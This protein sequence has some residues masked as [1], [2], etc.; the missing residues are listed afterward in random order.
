M[1]LHRLLQINMT[2]KGNALFDWLKLITGWQKAAFTAFV[3]MVIG[4]ASTFGYNNFSLP[5]SEKRM[6]HLEESVD[7][8]VEKSIQCDIQDALIKNN[9]SNLNIKVDEF[10][11]EI[12]NILKDLV[13]E[14]RE[15]SRITRIIKENTK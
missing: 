6:D 15:N 5:K 1:K 11:F 10:K 14:S 3:V 8:L 9:L 4:G 12:T 13:N 2:N 7:K